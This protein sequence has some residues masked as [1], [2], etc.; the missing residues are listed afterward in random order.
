MSYLQLILEKG[1]YRKLFELDSEV[2]MIK[3]TCNCNVEIFL[4]IA[5]A[6]KI[7][8]NMCR[9]SL[10]FSTKKFSLPIH[11]EFKELPGKKLL[12]MQ[13]RHE[14]KLKLVVVDKTTIIS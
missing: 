7:V 8:S 2:M 5:L 4:S 9:L 14:N 10:H 3:H 12:S 13:Q 1:S 11:G 6:G